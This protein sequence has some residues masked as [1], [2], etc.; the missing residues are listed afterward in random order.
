MSQA[1][2]REGK[3]RERNFREAKGKEKQ[4]EEPGKEEKEFFNFPREGND[5][6]GEGR[7]EENDS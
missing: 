2:K 7:E 5:F 6:Q 4:T 1:K 3:K